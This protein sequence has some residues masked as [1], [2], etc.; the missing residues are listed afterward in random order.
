VGA[1]LARGTPLPDNPGR[2]GW[3]GHGGRFGL[4]VALAL[5]TF[6][7]FPEAP[8]TQIPIYEVGAVA[9]DNVIAPFA[10][11]VNKTDAELQRERD[12]VARA[13]EPVFQFVP[14]ALDTTRAMLTR[15]QAALASALRGG[16]G[17]V[18][19]VQRTAALYGVALS[20]AEAA[21][22]TAPSRQTRMLATVRRVFD[23]WVAS[24]VTAS[25][26]L[27][28]VR[29]EI[30]LERG[31][32]SDRLPADSMIAFSQL[33]SRARL[34]E[35]D[36]RSEIAT[37]VYLKLIT[38]FFR[39]TLVADREA[40]TRRADDLRRSVR[41]NKYSVLAGEK[42]VGAH[43]VVGREEHEKLRVLQEMLTGIRSS[44]PRIR[45]STGAVLFDLLIVVLLGVTLRTLRP[46]LYDEWR[47]VVA[48]AALVALVVIIGA[49]VSHTRPLRPELLPVTLVAIVVSALFDQRISIVTTMIV[50]I[51]LGAQAPFRGTNAL[52]INLVGGAVAALSVRTVARRHQAYSWLILT[53]CAYLAAALAIGLMLDQSA[54]TIAVSAGF[55]A[56]NALASI[57]LALLVLPLAESYTGIET[58]L[59]LLEWSDLSRPLMQRLSLEAPGTFA[60][61]MVIANLAESACRAIGANAL[62]ARVGAYYHDIGKLARPQFF[63]ENQTQRNPH[64]TLGAV[65]SADIIRAHV[66]DG[67]AL[68]TQYRVP[69][70]VRAFITEHHG[71][72][73]I[74]FFRDK[75]RESG[76][77]AAAER[78]EYPGPIPKS[79]ETAVVMLAD[80]VEAATRVLNEPTPDRVREVIDHIVRQRL[81]QGQLR[82]TPLTLRQLEVVKSQFARVLSGTYHTRIEY[83]RASG[84]VT[85]EFASG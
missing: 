58:D 19:A 23:R 6:A 69:R 28:Q 77:T 79:A 16:P 24:G 13:A 56:L 36:P 60:H 83:P 70:A 7:L 27:D 68:A 10:F 9:A 38:S 66:T 42:I 35:P 63:V 72:G 84:G 18:I 62:L 31:D 48:L 75:A 49:V 64:D 29:G 61:T 45:R 20:P 65:D 5:L 12:D 67:V 8:A 73:T 17:D 50:T 44:E 22:L 71:T 74:S 57:L 25:G 76:E 4:A 26:A 34:I 15:F 1:P 3:T 47:D 51:L 78:F 14:G 33:I 40:T 2:S 37:S 46:R 30:L 81:E 53:G 82:E 52:F 85:A 11:N 54:P 80:G 43:Q 59:T 41:T 21:Y 39:P 55:G 32:H